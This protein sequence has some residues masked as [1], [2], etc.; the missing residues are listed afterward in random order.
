MNPQPPLL[1]AL[2]DAARM[3]NAMTDAKERFPNQFLS[4]YKGQSETIL[5]EFAPYLFWFDTTKDR[6]EDWFT[7]TG[8]GQSW[9]VFVRADASVETVYQHFRRFLIVRDE[10]GREM[11]FRFYDPRV[12]RNF[13]PTC[14]AAQ[15]ADF[16]GPVQQF[17]LEDAATETDLCFW[18]AQGQLQRRAI[19]RETTS[20]NE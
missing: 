1:F 10:Q 14:D 3:G 6:P 19:N 8:R 7:S 17:I 4:L 9:G 20:Q 11:Y 15:L 12:L 18:L 13:L 2:L 16:F 5:A